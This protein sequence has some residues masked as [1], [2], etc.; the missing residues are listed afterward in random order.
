MM[1]A[2]VHTAGIA[3]YFV[4]FLILLAASQVPRSNSA[5][6]Y[7]ACGTCAAGCARLTLLLLPATETLSTS[8]WLYGCLVVLEKLFL[9]VGVQRFFGRRLAEPT[10]FLAAALMLVGLSAMYL[11]EL[12]RWWFD[13]VLA[14]FNVAALLL[15][16][17]VMWQSQQALPVLVK[18]LALG[19]CL[20][21]ALHWAGLVSGKLWWFTSWQLQ[22]FVI[23]TLL[24]LVLYFSLL[25]AVFA[26]FR[27]RLIDSEEKA[28]AL[29]FQDPLT[30]L[31]NKRYVDV[32]FE[33][34]LLL[35]NRPHQ[36]LAV[37]YIDLDHFKPI[38]DTD[39]HRAGDGVLK[40]VARRLKQCLR[41]TDICARV[42]GDEFVVIATQLE[43]EQA[44]AE[45]ATKVLQQLAAPLAVAGKIYQLGA[46]VGVSLYPKDGKELS[47][48]LEKADIA[49][50]QV[51]RSGRHGF[52][53]FSNE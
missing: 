24:V 14:G 48:L 22:G 34:A 39:G 52:R 33:Q 44:A 30:G 3:V 47:G 35:A 29:A 32:L 36:L 16:S 12:P 42:G 45:I 21:L 37:Y 8:I 10:V 1:V 9:L 51:K 38:N 13:L 28:M 31:N 5:V 53:L 17:W 49:M 27:Q 43:H 26:V 20:L 11:A 19:S 25:A 23:G 18:R 40:E 6:G 15:I 41:S 7:W 2:S 4:F 46:S 50:Y